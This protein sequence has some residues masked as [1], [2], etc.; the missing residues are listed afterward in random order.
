MPLRFTVHILRAEEQAPLFK[1][2]PFYIALLSAMLLFTIIILQIFGLAH[3]AI[4][5]R[6]P[7]PMVS[8]CSPIFQPLGI[9]VLD[10]NCNNHPVQHN[11]GPYNSNGVGCIL[12]PG[13]QQLSWLRATV[14]G[15]S[16]SLVFEA[17][18]IGVLAFVSSGYRWR[19]VKMRR[20]WCTMIA[21]VAT[22][23]LLLIF[24]ALYGDMLPPGIT[25]RVW[26]LRQDGPEVGVYEG[27]LGPAGLMVAIIVCVYGLF[28]AWGGIYSGHYVG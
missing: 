21:G 8:H 5:A 2:K 26:V 12:L 15:I 22:L 28:E 27:W 9:T 24:G 3:A 23:F 18:D 17:I 14:A 7:L 20:P 6:Q 19:E 16:T 13:L 11:G 1:S 4:A 25:S 10:G